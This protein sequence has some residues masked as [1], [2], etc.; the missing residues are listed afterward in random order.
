MVTMADRA[1][2]A[3]RPPESL[4]V[5][6][7]LLDHST[8]C[9]VDEDIVAPEEPKLGRCQFAPHAMERQAGRIFKADTPLPE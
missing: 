8:G 2:A 5:Q 4:V 7:A 6:T 1:T 9:K 3:I